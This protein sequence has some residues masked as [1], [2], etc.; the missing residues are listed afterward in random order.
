M[1]STRS[2]VQSSFPATHWSVV[3][4]VGQGGGLRG[5]EALEELFKRYWR[6]LYF[7]IR[8]R[9]YGREE[10]ED[11]VQGFF[12]H[13]LV[14]GAVEK[15]DPGR[16]RFRSYLLGCLN[17]FLANERQRQGALKRGGGVLMKGVEVEEAERWLA[18][19]A[20]GEAAPD[21]VYDRQWALAVLEEGLCRLESEYVT[22]GR[23]VLF[24][25]LRMYLQGEG[26]EESYQE[27]AGR[28]GTTSG[29]VA[30]SV[31]RLRKRYRH[32]LRA[33]VL[34]TVSQPAEVD[35]ELA[36]LLAALRG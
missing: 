3:L 19:Q 31:H 15:A 18:R 25:E 6:P 28:L 8:R 2:V 27:I 30:V 35:L 32:V 13:L 11:L 4:A 33:V 22:S 23:E 5:E 1:N 16:G 36:E 14:T 20:S 9:G 17:H 34:E 29:T 21:R 24:R 26:S 12:E 7:F 10:S